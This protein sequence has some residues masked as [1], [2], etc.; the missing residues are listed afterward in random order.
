MTDEVYGG[1]QYGNVWRF[2]LTDPNP[3]NWTVGLLAKLT[4]PDGT[5]QPVTTAP[6]IEV[7]I[8]NG[9]DRWVF[10]GTG[11]LLDNS[12][13]DNEQIQ[14]F[15]AIRDGTQKLPS[16]IVTGSPTIRS[17]LA[18]VASAA[19]TG[20]VTAKGWV[21]DL[22]QFSQVTTPYQ[23]VLS[24]VVYAATKPQT[25]PCLTG[26]QADIYVR[27]FA[28][29]VSQIDSSAATGTGISC[30]DESC[31]SDSGAVNAEIIGTTRDGSPTADLAVAITLGTTGQ[32]AKIPI[33]Q[34]AWN[35]THRLSW[36]IL[37]E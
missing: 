21:D 5:V 15:Y 24:L 30:S 19:G 8:V 28:T 34:P 31:Q 29:G 26:Q 17:D 7:D 12:D 23:A 3:A 13:L 10:V 25:D 36:R 6:Q 4:A 16:E 35:Y 33:K 18:V 14:S 32:L 2:D 22:P 11:R 37:S 9:A 20:S 1:D 27:S